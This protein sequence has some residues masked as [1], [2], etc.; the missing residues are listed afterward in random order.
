MEFIL[1]WCLLKYDMN[2]NVSLVGTFGVTAIQLMS[3]CKSHEYHIK[4]VFV[5]CN[6][7]YVNK[8]ICFF[9]ELQC[10]CPIYTYCKS[11]GTCRG[12]NL[13]DRVADCT[14]PKS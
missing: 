9:S 13:P 5:D 12:G 7:A 6:S 4:V 2:S 8:R 3:S 11:H 10:V 1:R 14:R